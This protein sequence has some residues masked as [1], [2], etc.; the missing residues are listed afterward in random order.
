MNK[1]ALLV[2]YTQARALLLERC[3]LWGEV[4]TP[5]QQTFGSNCVSVIMKVGK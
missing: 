2:C 5:A 3:G 4:S 1:C